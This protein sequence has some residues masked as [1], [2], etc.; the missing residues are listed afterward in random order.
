ML[1]HLN[2]EAMQPASHRYA[3][4]MRYG[5][6]ATFNI[7]MRLFYKQFIIASYLD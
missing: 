7:Y 6:S 3:A 5:I 4:A 1:Y 2:L